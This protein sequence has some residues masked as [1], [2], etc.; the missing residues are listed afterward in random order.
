MRHSDLTAMQY[1][2]ESLTIVS[3]HEIP[4]TNMNVLILEFSGRLYP[5]YFHDVVTLNF[6]N[7]WLLKIKGKLRAVS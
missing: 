6:A 2:L 3:Y 7:F 4:H 1:S 5:V